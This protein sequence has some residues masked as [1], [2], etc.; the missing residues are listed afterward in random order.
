VNVLS[1]VDLIEQYGNLAFG[2]DFYTDVLDLDYL[3]DHL[4]KDPFAKKFT[5]LNKEICSLIEDYNLVN[6][7]PLSVLVCRSHTSYMPID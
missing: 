6:F 4:D 2:L 1:K 7:V 5:K 3:A